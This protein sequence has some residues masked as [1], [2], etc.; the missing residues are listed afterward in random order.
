MSKL[1]NKTDTSTGKSYLGK[2]KTDEQAMDYFQIRKKD[3]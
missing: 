2:I 3:E 1:I